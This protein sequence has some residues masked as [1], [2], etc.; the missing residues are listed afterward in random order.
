M[1][2]G[3]LS[4]YFEGVAV[5]HLSSVEAD[6]STSNQ[7]EFNGVTAMKKMLGTG[8]QIFHTQ[9]LYLGEGE[10]DV[11]VAECFLTWYDAREKHLTRSEYRLY[12]PS[13]LDTMLYAP[14]MAANATNFD[15]S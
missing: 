10:D 11:L 8:R 15:I 13:T 4:T 5:K 7:H 12:F 2:R 14:C 3:F 1:K 9:F 6:P